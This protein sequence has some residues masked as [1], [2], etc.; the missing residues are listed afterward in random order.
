M[1][2]LQA[3]EDLLNTPHLKV[4]RA[5]DTRWLSHEG[6]CQTLVKILPAVLTSLSREAEE[7]GDALALGLWTVIKKYDFIA[8]LYMMCDV[9]PIVNRLSRILQAKDIDLS[10]LHGLVSSTVDGLKG[11]K[12]SNGV[13][14]GK[15]ETDITGSLSDFNISFTSNMK[16]LFR[17]SI[18]LPFLDSLIKHIQERLP[19][20]SLF[21]AFSIFDTR[22]LPETALLAASQNYG[23]SEVH[24]AILQGRFQWNS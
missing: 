1:S 17:T 13:Y 11:L 20:T 5:A 7:R 21:A 12:T 8:T 6:A 15:I 4:K 24:S 2:G 3:I 18:Y 23:S 22:T 10:Q 9:L 14:L 19:D 16:T